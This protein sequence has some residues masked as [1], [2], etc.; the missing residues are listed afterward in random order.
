MPNERNIYGLNDDRNNRLLRRSYAVHDDQLGVFNSKGLTVANLITQL[1]TLKST[2]VTANDTQEAAK[3]DLRGK[4]ATA[5]AAQQAA[6]DNASTNLD[7]VIGILGK[8]TGTGQASRAHS[9]HPQARRPEWS[10]QFLSL[11]VQF[12]FAPAHLIFFKFLTLEQPARQ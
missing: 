6:Y 8:K 10:E 11:G 3:A 7:A 5:N 12:V 1:G 9:Q 2:L 4:T